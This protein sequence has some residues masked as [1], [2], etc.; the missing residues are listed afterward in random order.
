AKPLCGVALAAA[1]LPNAIHAQDGASLALE[2]IIVTA[3]RR[4]RSLQDVPVAVTALSGDTILNE[5][6]N[7]VQD[8]RYVAPS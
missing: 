5:N 6:L 8:L 3:E 4:E 2:E 1:S 7:S